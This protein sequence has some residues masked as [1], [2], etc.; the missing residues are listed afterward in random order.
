MTPSPHNPP[1]P[2]RALPT[3][4]AALAL[5]L[6]AMAGVP[7]G[8]R[9]AGPAQAGPAAHAA[10]AQAAPADSAVFNEP[11][12]EGA[13]D[14]SLTYWNGTY[15]L[16]FTEVD[17][18]AVVTGKRLAD[19]HDAPETVV[20]RDSTPSRCCD[21]WAPELHFLDGRWYLYYTADD[22]DIGRHHLFVLQGGATPLGPY[23]FGGQLTTTDGETGIDASVLE[24]GGARYL[25]WSGWD[26]DGQD[27]FIA[28]M[29]T[30]LTVSGARTKISSPTYAWER[31][32][33][34]V[35]EGPEVLQHDGR[36]FLV[37][38]ASQC[39][40]PD[41][42]LGMLTFTGGD[43]LAPASWVKSEQPVFSRNDAAG[44]FG[45][46][47][48]SFFTSPDGT[49]TWNAYHATTNPAGSCGGDRST[50][51]QQVLWNP[52]GTPDFGAPAALGTP[53][54]VPSGEPGSS[55]GGA[56]TLPLD[57]RVS[58]RVT[59]PGFTDRSLRH[60]NG[61]AVTSQVTAASDPTT[62]LDATF[63]VRPGLADPACYSLESTNYPGSYL[64][65]QNF[66]VRLDADDHSSLF[67]ADA[68]FCAVPGLAGHDLSLRSANFPDRYLRH[69]D[70]EVWIAADGGP[71]PSD[72][73]AH[74]TDD[75]T[76]E[77]N[78]AWAD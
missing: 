1:H 32:G 12:R 46:G 60:Q 5:L 71:L 68:T 7:A 34:P 10:A 20:W 19:L 36:T 3:L 45:P 70:S 23:A 44:V 16:T 2:R 40:T 67:A 74:F 37:Y 26:G 35:N 9:A 61:L 13:A 72:A 18:I 53:I 38:S 54:A 76:W 28:A 52:D 14:P 75:A 8:A 78:A 15:Y 66:R 57:Q 58:L 47:H 49:Q 62:L 24:L 51:A 4:L 69:F 33:D 11:I 31:N 6:A 77:Q 29:P 17:H 41:Y 65:H 25:L 27:L 64:R 73:P 48:N 39:H 50:R 56:A 55:A 63:T 30:P 42:A 59:T 43:P 22:G 21:I